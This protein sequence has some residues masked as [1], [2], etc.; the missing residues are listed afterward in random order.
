MA[1]TNFSLVAIG[2]LLMGIPILMHLLMKQRP[3]H[4]IFPAL[5]FL[6]QRQIA[7]K[8]QL[9]LRNW[10]LLLLRMIAIGLLAALFARPSVDSIAL[11]DWVKTILLG[12]LAPLAIL[13][14]VWSWMQQKGQLLIATTGVLSVLL[15]AALAFFAF[16]S[17]TADGNSTLGDAQAPVAAVLV[18]D[19]S[20]RMGLRHANLTRLEEAR[21]MARELMKQLPADS[22]VAIVDAANTGVFSVDLGTAANMI[23]SLDIT[24]SEYPLHDLV[25]Q[26]IEL[27][28][29]REDKRQEVYVLT[30]LSE[31]VWQ[32][33]EFTSVR[34]RLTQ[35]DGISLFVLD[36][37]VQSPRNVQLGQLRL[38]TDSIAK[39]QPLHI[40][41][42]LTGLNID[43]EVE[44]E[45]TLE[46]PDATRPV[47]VD[48]E[49]LLPEL[50]PRDRATQSVTSGSG[51]TVSFDL[52]NLPTGIHHG[53]VKIRS[54]DGLA[55][56]NVRYFTVEV[57][58]PHPV[59]LV[60]FDGTT[61]DFV[62]QAISP[63]EF[64]LR[65]RSEFDCHVVTP[66]E[67]ARTN[68]DDFVVVGLLDPGPMASDRWRK[69]NDFVTAGGGL[70]AFLG[71]NIRNA[72]TFNQQTGGL[73]PIEV[74]KHWRTAEDDFLFFSPT[75]LSHPVLK[76]FRN[77]EAIVAWQ[78][79]PIIRHWVGP[80]KAD[81]NVIT[82]FTNNKPAIIESITGQ[83]R[84]VVVTTPF[85]D[86]WKKRPAWNR[87]ATTLPSFMLL[88]GIFPYLADQS[89][90]A[91][92]HDVGQPVV[93]S[94]QDDS[95]GSEPSFESETWQMVTPRGDWQNVR[96]ENGIVTVTSTDA[97]GAWRLKPST[98]GETGIGFSVNLPNASTN[99]KRLEE[100]K[101][102]EVLGANA[103]TIARGTGEINRGI[104]RA[105]VG[106]EL[107]PFL[108]LV[109]VGLLAMEHLMSNRFYS[110]NSNRNTESRKLQ[111][112]A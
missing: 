24:G 53:Q 22:E 55:V 47:I 91:W 62:K 42:D 86:E 94:T 40:D 72:E 17:F 7:N 57:R 76:L 67:F 36:V 63:D 2:S 89:D 111:S 106:R 105:R 110:T 18:F 109:V 103:Y 98:P 78:D 70:V 83:G 39:G 61:P 65:G 50:T 25:L 101:L 19:T 80:V 73:L 30:E 112:A 29:Q 38:S 54:E 37:G 59:L 66:E 41:C 102:D 16:R 33:R 31:Q 48:G 96:T 104:G 12:V 64:E 56:D 82:T 10:L 28:R 74:A 69:L 1:W 5:R 35:I 68:L 84:V 20:P 87:I 58:P 23:D 43:E 79:A 14:C 26:G 75:S 88:R 99:I 100:G 44:V 92:N 8:R 77:Q 9:R 21:T 71:G 97:A 27:A 4:Q 6:Q 93:V 81:A 60:A 108:V 51:S 45:V 34:D 85:T 90:G 11:G 95:V 52:L 15:C 107:F 13:A 46:E 49:L 32:T 3:R